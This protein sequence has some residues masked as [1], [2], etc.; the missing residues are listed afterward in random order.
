MYK[1]KDHL[2]VWEAVA[3]RLGVLAHGFE[4]L[5]PHLHAFSSVV[6]QHAEVTSQFVSKTYTMHGKCREKCD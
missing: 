1:Q 5:N 3:H 6:R 4:A 2:S